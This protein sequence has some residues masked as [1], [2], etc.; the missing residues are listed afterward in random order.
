MIIASGNSQ[1][2]LSALADHSTTALKN[3]GLSAITEGLNLSDWILIDSGDIIL[4]LFRPEVRLFYNLER[5]WT[6]NTNLSS[7]S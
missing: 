6:P 3:Y 1:R 5:L 7:V 2:H 4:H